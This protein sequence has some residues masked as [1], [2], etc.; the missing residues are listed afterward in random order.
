MIFPVTSQGTGNAGGLEYGTGRILRVMMLKESL[1]GNL[2]VS[3][4]MK[5]EAQR[6][7]MTCLRSHSKFGERTKPRSPGGG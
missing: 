6:D 5:I 2:D 1:K 4:D 3:A 7:D